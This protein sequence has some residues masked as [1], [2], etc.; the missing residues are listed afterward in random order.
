VREE[1]LGHG[2][3]WMP[4]RFRTA[5]HPGSA[6][7]GLPSIGSIDFGYAGRHWAVSL[8]TYEPCVIERRTL[9]AREMRTKIVSRRPVR[10]MC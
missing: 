2:F 8:F 7:R 6:P 3:H 9:E 1:S 5:G 10:S 4:W